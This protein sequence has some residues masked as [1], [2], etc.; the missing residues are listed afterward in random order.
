MVER[1]CLD[2]ELRMGFKGIEAVAVPALSIAGAPRCGKVSNSGVTATRR[3]IGPELVKFPEG[4]E[5]PPEEFARLLEGAIAGSDRASAAAAVF[6][7]FPKKGSTAFLEGWLPVAVASGGPTGFTSSAFVGTTSLVTDRLLRKG[8]SPSSAGRRWGAADGGSSLETVGLAD[9]DSETRM[10]TLPRCASAMAM[11]PN[12]K[13]V[14]K[15]AIRNKM[16]FMG[17]VPETKQTV[18][19]R[20]AVG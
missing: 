20:Q 7:N 9:S 6:V 2:R 1:P 11:N 12:T 8:F 17:K 13:T 4:F 16:R 14:A 10:S 19:C 18:R 3:D 15:A 5:K